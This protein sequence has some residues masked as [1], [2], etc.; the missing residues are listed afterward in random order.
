LLS[1]NPTIRILRW[2]QGFTGNSV[3]AIDA[4][5]IRSVRRFLFAEAVLFALLPIFAAAMARG[6]G[7]F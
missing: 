7:V 1:I 3:S 4:A 5:D 2:R 6:Y